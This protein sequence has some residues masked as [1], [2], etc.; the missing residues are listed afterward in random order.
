MR[1]PVLIEEAE[2]AGGV[3]LTIGYYMKKNG[4]GHLFLRVKIPLVKRKG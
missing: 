3:Q 2:F 4:M 1:S